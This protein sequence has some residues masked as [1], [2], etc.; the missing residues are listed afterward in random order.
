MKSHKKLS[1]IAHLIDLATCRRTT[2]GVLYANTV[3][4]KHIL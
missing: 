3:T 2:N 4:Q 1:K